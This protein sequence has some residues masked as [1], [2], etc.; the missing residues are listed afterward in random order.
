MSFGNAS[1][2]PYVAQPVPKNICQLKKSSQIQNNRVQGGRPKQD[3]F[4]YQKDFVTSN[5][6]ALFLLRATT[7]L[8][9]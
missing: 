3:T 7:G 6:L 8:N 4:N 5:D 9:P 2:H 1:K